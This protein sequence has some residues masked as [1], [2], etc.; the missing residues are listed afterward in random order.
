MGYGK[1]VGGAELAWDTVFPTHEFRGRMVGGF[2][3]RR[4]VVEEQW[5]RA[6]GLAAGFAIGIA[7]MGLLA[8]TAL[9]VGRRIREI[10]IR[11]ALGASVSGILLLLSREFAWLVAAGNAVAWPVAYWA[12]S[13]WLFGAAGRT[14]T[15][16]AT[17]A[18]LL[19]EC[20]SCADTTDGA[21][22]A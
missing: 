13:L 5:G 4:Y 11:K 14:G 15:C 12:T 10:G 1:G 2:R 21:R 8:L 20:S 16:R 22:V 18:D 6:F 7:C 19:G 17:G 9:A 3:A